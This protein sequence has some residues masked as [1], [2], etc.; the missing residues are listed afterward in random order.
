MT[1]IYM[2]GKLKYNSKCGVTAAVDI[3]NYEVISQR[4]AKDDDRRC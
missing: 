1:V 3:N 4:R 2:E